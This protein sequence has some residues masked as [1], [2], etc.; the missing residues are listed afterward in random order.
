MVIEGVDPQKASAPLTS[1]VGASFDDFFKS[2][3]PEEPATAVDEDKKQDEEDDWGDDAFQTAEPVVVAEETKEPTS[4]AAEPLS[5]DQ[6]F[7]LIQPPTKQ[8]EV[9]E[10]MSAKSDEWGDFDKKSPEKHDG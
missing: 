1:L 9:K 7:D 3:K 5:L 6:A 2:Q 8:E 10:V 4:T